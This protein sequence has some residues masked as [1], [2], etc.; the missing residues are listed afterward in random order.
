[1]DLDK[2]ELVNE[3]VALGCKTPLSL[4]YVPSSSR[5][6]SKDILECEFKDEKNVDILLRSDLMVRRRNIMV[7]PKIREKPVREMIA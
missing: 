1:M 6:Q 2:E 5:D 7:L 4:E 3:I